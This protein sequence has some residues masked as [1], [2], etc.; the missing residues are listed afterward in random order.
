MKYTIRS[1]SISG[2]VVG[3]TDSL[4]KRGEKVQT[5]HGEC[6]VLYTL[7]DIIVVEGRPTYQGEPRHERHD[8]WSR[9]AW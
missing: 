3:N 9:D 6:I 8:D 4:P 1:G 5:D 7:H 2:L